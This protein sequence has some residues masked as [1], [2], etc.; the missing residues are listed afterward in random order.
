[1]LKS[2]QPRIAVIGAGVTGCAAAYQLCR[3]GCTVTLLERGAI[4]AHASSQNAGNLNPL[5]GTPAPLVPLALAAFRLHAQIRAE[6][7]DLGCARCA[8][9]QVGRIYLGYTRTDLPRLRATAALFAGT[10]GFYSAWLTREELLRIEPRLAAD[11]AFGVL[12]QGNLT[13]DGLEF[14]LSLAAGAS[15]LG[16]AL[17]AEEVLGVTTCHDRVISVNTRHGTLECDG[18]VLAT[19]PWI[20]EAR[21]WLGVEVPVEPV[22]GEILRVRLSQPVPTYDLTWETTS[23]YRRGQD[24]W[25]GTTTKKCGLDSI[26]TAEARDVLL[27]RAARM[28]PELGNACVLDHL[29]AVRPMSLHG[30]PIASRAAG[31]QN[32]YIANGGGSKG[33]LWSVSIAKAIADLITAGCGAS[34]PEHPT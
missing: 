19:G 25:I 3:V 6:L 2:S 15:R 26:P 21:S 13:I 16:C 34:A 7:S 22:K 8:A 1:M 30:R 5:H 31:W 10:A 32:V 27:T 24:T 28:M 20:A 12:A 23:I 33:L 29:A 11:T 9:V 4:A 14:A 17:L 18:I